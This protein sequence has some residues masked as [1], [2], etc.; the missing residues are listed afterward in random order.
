[1]ERVN[2]R[3][4]KL[5][6]V[7]LTTVCLMAL[8]G[9]ANAVD[10]KQLTQVYQPVAAVGENLAQ[11]VYVRDGKNEEQKSNANIYVDGD[12]HT[13][14]IP[15][16]FT[17]FCVKPGQHKV[18][19]FLKDE[20]LYQ[21]KHT[22]STNVLEMKGGETYYLV[23]D[24][25]ASNSLTLV[26]EAQARPL[27]QEAKRQDILLNRAS[28]VVPCEYLY[29]DFVLNSDVL[30]DFGKYARSNITQTGHEEISR[31]ASEL[32]KH[33]NNVTV[34]GHTD[35]IGSENS[36]MVLGM[37]RAQTVAGLLVD[38][39]IPAENLNTS[40]AGSKERVTEQCDNLPRSEK[41]AC[42]APER[43][44]VIRVYK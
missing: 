1:M 13:A 36:N 16:S 25:D 2:G 10:G 17:T 41:I 40:S 3:M 8:V 44:V 33:S 6:I 43:R 12:F 7:S 32:S 34:I 4:K 29:T 24:E 39:G 5:L 37:K 30:F 38:A 15:G 9:Q 28:S 42:Y 14:L 35:P 31:I 22:S 27:L 19:S 26:T 20:P 21:G 11:V 18:G 23:A